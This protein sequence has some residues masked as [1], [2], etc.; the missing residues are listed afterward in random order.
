MSWTLYITFSPNWQSF[1]IF[2]S[3]VAAWIAVT[4][5]ASR[6]QWFTNQV[7]W[8][9]AQQKSRDPGWMLMPASPLTWASSTRIS[10]ARISCAFSAPPM[11]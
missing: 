4:P 5:E 9:T 2:S 11:D 1:G 6:W 8:R 3:P 7:A 10:P